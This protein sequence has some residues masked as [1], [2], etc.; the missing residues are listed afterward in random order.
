MAFRKAKELAQLAVRDSP[1]AA[2]YYLLCLAC[3]RMGERGEAMKAI[4]QAVQLA[5]DNK[6]YARVHTLLDNRKK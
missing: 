5:P 6:Q 2:N 4:K 1:T 3:D